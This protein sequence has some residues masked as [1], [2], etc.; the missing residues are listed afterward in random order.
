M[1][2]RTL[3]QTGTLL[4]PCVHLCHFSSTNLG[5]FPLEIQR[6]TLFSYSPI[7]LAVFRTP[8]LTMALVAA[9]MTSLSGLFSLSIKIRFACTQY[10][11][12]VAS[13]HSQGER[14]PFIVITFRCPFRCPFLNRIK[15]AGPVFA[16][17]GR[18]VADR[19]TG[20]EACAHLP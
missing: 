19:P 10:E 8:N 13:L 4:R 7:S 16:E 12:T 6:L 15:A 3:F 14:F 18:S 20:S 2:L 17:S 5:I 11:Q 1:N 9:F